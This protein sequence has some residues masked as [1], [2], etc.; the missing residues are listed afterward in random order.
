LL[1]LLFVTTSNGAVQTFVAKY[2]F[3]RGVNVFYG[4]ALGFILPT[5][6]TAIVLLASPNRRGAAI[7]VHYSA[8]DIGI[9]GGLFMSKSLKSK[10]FQNQY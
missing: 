1:K 7:A 9:G 6:N 10:V 3:T 2:A 4:L 8:I 5:I